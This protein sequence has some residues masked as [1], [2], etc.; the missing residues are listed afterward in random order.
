MLLKIQQIYIIKEIYNMKLLQAIPYERITLELAESLALLFPN[1][2]LVCS[3][4]DKMVL[5][6]AEN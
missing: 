4:D 1:D 6:Y 3:A 2:S 5:V